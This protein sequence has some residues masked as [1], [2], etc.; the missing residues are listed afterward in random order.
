MQLIKVTS[1][2]DIN[3]M[4]RQ[5]YAKVSPSLAR[6]FLNSRR[7]QAKLSPKKKIFFNDNFTLESIKGTNA[8]GLYEI[9]RF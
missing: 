8:Q 2:E 1:V 5:T 4:P 6:A 3:R 9:N 7:R